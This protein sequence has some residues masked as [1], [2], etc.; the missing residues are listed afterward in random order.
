MYTLYTFCYFILDKVSSRYR[1]PVFN[2]NIQEIN[3]KSKNKQT[4]SVSKDSKVVTKSPQ[5]L[6]FLL[7]PAIKGAFVT[8]L[9]LP[10]PSLFFVPLHCP[11]IF[12]S[13]L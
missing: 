4:K 5:N 1:R 8:S 3:I 7:E 13:L 12:L 9:S 11:R 6:K 10:S 2:Q